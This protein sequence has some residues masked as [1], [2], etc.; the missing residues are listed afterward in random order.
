ME[1]QLLG[2]GGVRASALC[3]AAKMHG[4]E[5]NQGATQQERN[6]IFD[7]FIGA[8]G[9]FIDTMDDDATEASYNDPHPFADLIA[10]E[11]EH[12]VIASGCRLA[13]HI[14]GPHG[15]GSHRKAVLKTL[16]ARL[17]ALR[18]EYLDLYWIHNWDYFTPTE[19]VMGAL[20]DAMAAG[21]IR[22][23]G[24]ATSDGWIIN[25][26]NTVADWRGWP[27]S[28]AVKAPYNL[29]LRD[30]EQDV[31]PV[32]QTFK[33]PTIATSPL[34]GGILAGRPSRSFIGQRE[35]A[36]IAQLK[37]LAGEIGCTPAQLAL[38]WL[39]QRRANAIIPLLTIDTEAQI[40][41]CLDCEAYSLT[42]DQLRRLE[43]NFLHPSLPPSPSG[44]VSSSSNDASSYSTLLLHP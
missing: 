22:H 36:I 32:A 41:E 43:S 33:M 28:I 31:L 34:A 17:S 7:A 8:G 6:R 37:T 38:A 15:D 18:T 10:A 14:A 21:K 9:N 5:E 4:N 12:L 25:L 20:A 40:R 23:I 26:A 16:N 27:P 39:Q 35:R 11:R 3:L 42:H 2:E 44:E 19:E 29:M 13:S 30:I 24:I 1:Y